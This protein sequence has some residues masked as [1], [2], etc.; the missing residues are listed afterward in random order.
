MSLRCPA[1][2]SRVLVS[3]FLGHR[4]PANKVSK[5]NTER[6]VWKKLKVF[7]RLLQAR[8][9]WSGL[10]QQTVNLSP[11]GLRWFES[12]P[13]HPEPRGVQGRHAPNM[14]PCH[15]NSRNKMY[16]VYVLKSLKD[17][18]LYIGYSENLKR[19]FSEHQSG[20]VPSTKP[21]RPFEL[22][23]YEAYKAMSDAKRREMYFKTNKGKSSLKMMLKDYFDSTSKKI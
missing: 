1:E 21:R 17:H 12:N 23:F 8:R 16:Y 7:G 11:I 2:C 18:K 19:R 5:I 3:V 9:W 13:T 4:P 6:Q 14:V 15:P 22:I 20:K 10:S